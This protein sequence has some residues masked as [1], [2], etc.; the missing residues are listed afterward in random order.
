MQKIKEE[1][2]KRKVFHDNAIEKLFGRCK[3]FF[4]VRGDYI[5]KKIKKNKIR[6]SFIPQI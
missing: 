4:D 3:K 2:N 6:L 1:E 5:A